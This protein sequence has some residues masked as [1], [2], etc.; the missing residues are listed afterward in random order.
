MASVRKRARLTVYLDLVAAVEEVQ[1]RI[2]NVNQ[3]IKDAA[4]MGWDN[5]LK[6]LLDERDDWYANLV[7]E[8]AALTKH[9]RTSIEFEE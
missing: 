8:T 7:Q 2:E 9:I 6:T 3:E 1:D 5:Q 4:R